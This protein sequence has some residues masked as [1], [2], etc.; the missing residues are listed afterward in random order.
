MKNKYNWLYGILFGILMVFLFS[1]MIQ[2]QFRPFEF[3]KMNGRFAVHKMPDLNFKSYKDGSYQKGAE[4]YLQTHFGFYEPIVRGYNQYCWDFYRKSMVSYIKCGKDN[5]LFYDHT[6]DNY[7]GT[8]MYN[9]YKDAEAAQKGYEREIRLLHK[10]HGIL[11]QYGVTLMTVIAPSKG[12]IYS[13]L[14]PRGDFDTTT[15][16]AADYY[17][18]RFDELDMPYLD[19]TEVFFQMKD[20]CSFHLFQPHG[21]HWNFSCIYAADTLFHFMEQQ[22]GIKMPQIHYGNQWLDSCCIGNDKF[23]DL[24]VE[25]NLMRPIKFD[26]KY[27]YQERKY[28]L[29]CDSTVTKPAVLINGNSFYLWMMYYI[30]PKECFSDFQFWYYNKVAYQG[31]DL[32]IDSVSRLNCL[33]YLLDADYVIWFTNESQVY[34]NTE[35]FASDAILQLCI[36]QERFDT[37]YQ[38]VYDSLYLDNLTYWR[39][40]GGCDDELFKHLL[41]KYTKKMLHDDPEQFFPELAGEGI[42]KARCSQ[43]LD[44]N[45]W[46]KR[47]IRRQIKRDPDW[48]VKVTNYMAANNVSLEQAVNEETDNVF[49]G[50]PLMRDARVN[51]AEYINILIQQMEEKIRNYQEWFDAVK[52]Q[53]QKEGITVDEAVHNHATYAVEQQIYEGK[54]TLPNFEDE[55]QDKP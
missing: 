46:K 1:F 4:K 5:W 7:Y 50:R 36:D 41:V 3:E 53:A 25:L 12:T 42:P 20:T 8:E 31:L 19:M 27:N 48:M 15:L 45:Y 26:P 44:E 54:I 14:L 37:R 16:N 2:E 38:E 35:G 49:F 22:R 40:A 23:T 21:H 52:Q 28:W 39:I 55:P 18:K 6:I 33:D 34:H 11:S 10:V 32:R 51:R 43:V 30:P 9:W 47:D 17:M 24:E 29:T 13:E